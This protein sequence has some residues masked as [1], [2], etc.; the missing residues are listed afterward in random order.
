MTTGR[1]PLAAALLVSAGL[2]LTAWT[3]RTG[4]VGGSDS[5][6]YALMTTA[7]AEGRTQPRSALALVA[8]WPEAT[9][10]A[11]PGGF[12]PSASRAGAAVPICAPGYSLLVTPLVLIAGPGAVHAVPPLAASL[13]AFLAFLLGRRLATAWAGVGAAL[14]VATHPIVLF[15]AVQP[16]NDIT[17]AALWTG[18]A[19]AMLA[20][21]PG[22]TGVLI[23]LGLLVRPNLAPAAVVAVLGCGVVTARLASGE[24]ARR[25]VR[26]MAVAAGAALPGVAAA[27]A[28]NAS[29]YGSPLQSGYGDL[30]ALFAWAHVPDNVV[31]YGGTWLTTSTP[32]VLLALAAPW[33]VR[34]PQRTA[35]WLLLSLAGGLTLVYLAYRPFTE[36]WYLRFLLPAVALSLVLAASSLAGVAV[37]LGG[38]TGAW[39]AALVILLAGVVASRT[40]EAGDAFRLAG[41]ESRFPLTS[42]VVATRLPDSTVVVT[43]WQSGAVRFSPGREV[44]MWDALDPAWLDRAVEWLGAAGHTPVIA[45]EAWE[46]EGF[47]A[48]FAGQT[49]GALDWP[50]RY[51]ID[52]RAHIFIP[53]DRARYLRHEPYVTEHVFPARR[54]ER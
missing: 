54:L 4:A 32:I 22:L 6:C 45:L 53:A 20:A 18:V 17:T 35:A 21:R 42:E 25:A 26:A 36:W 2:G 14:L 13:L 24:R 5:A 3:W 28:L 7:Y 30:G 38:R 43:S 15:Q 27:L 33:A 39:L 52:R 37:R 9:R 16:M 51:D 50:P 1:A 41:L 31:R 48:R 49:Y 40:P 34:S 44:V 46:E 12:L 19:A 11:A 10:V 29:L 23:G 47:R 8:P